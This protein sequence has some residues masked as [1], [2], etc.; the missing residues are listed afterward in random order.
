VDNIKQEINNIIVPGGDSTLL[1]R[2]FRK[3]DSVFIFGQGRVNI[4]HIGGSHVQAGIFPD[5]IRRNLDEINNGVYPPRGF[6][7]PYKVAKTNNTLNYS[8]KYKGTW[9]VARNVRKDRNVPLGVGGIAVYTKDP[10]AEIS[11]RLNVDSFDTRWN[12]DR[13][14]LIGYTEDNINTIQ[15]RLKIGE[16][17]YLEAEYDTI[18]QVYRYHL[19]TLSDSFT[20]VFPQTGTL[21]Q[22][23]V[24]NG[25]IPEKDEPGIVYHSIGVNG[26]AVSSFLDC[27]N[28]EKELPLISPDMVIFAI[29]INDAHSK[30]FT[31]ERFIDNYDLLIKRILNVNPDC[32]FLFITNNDS[33]LRISRRKYV[34]NRRG[35]IAR[36]AFYKL[37][38]RYSGG[39]WDLFSIMGG[40]GSMKDWESLGLAKRDKIHFTHNGYELLGDAFFEAIMRYYM[41]L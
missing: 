35:E 22:T 33:F 8:V 1:N 2:F 26:A 41:E 10:E 13:L 12:F 31:E 30:N 18:T 32:A 28:F 9:N 27:E 7:F 21:P 11:I 4:M 5:K 38:E 20:V 34:V 14:T 17:N 29:G 16:S 19:P 24:L 15:P 39:V 3:L 23:F 25:F 37:A 40:L 6:I 36:K